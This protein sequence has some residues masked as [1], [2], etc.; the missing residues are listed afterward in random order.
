MQAAGEQALRLGAHA[1]FLEVAAGIGPPRALYDRLG[2][3]ETGRR[4]GY[5]HRRAR[6]NRRTPSFCVAISRFRPLGKGRPLGK[7]HPKLRDPG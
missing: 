5:L 4:K 3:A 2:F 1:L 7:L 6:Q